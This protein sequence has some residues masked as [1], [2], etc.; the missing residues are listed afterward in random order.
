LRAHPFLYA[1]AHD[2]QRTQ[3]TMW[4]GFFMLLALG[5]IMGI[6]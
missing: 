3:F 1:I 4:D 6:A 5:T 2:L